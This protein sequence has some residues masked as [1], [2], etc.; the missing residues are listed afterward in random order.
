M[1]VNFAQR[2][3]QKKSFIPGL[4]A[5]LAFWCINFIAQNAFAQQAVKSELSSDT[6]FLKDRRA[7]KTI[8]VRAVK[9][10][11]AGA[12]VRNFSIYGIDDGLALRSVISGFKDHDGNL[13]FGTGGGGVSKFDGHTFTN[14]DER[15][16]IGNGV[17]RAIGQ[18]KSGNYYFG[19]RT[20]LSVY[21]GESI[22]NHYVRE[23]FPPRPI[24]CMTVDAS[25]NVW[26]GTHGGGLV[27][28]DGQKFTTYTTQNGLSSDIIRSLEIDKNGLLWIGTQDGVTTFDGDQ[29]KVFKTP[30]HSDNTVY[31]IHQDSKGNVWFACAEGVLK[32]DGRELNY[33][34]VKDGLSDSQILSIGESRDGILWFGTLEGG[35]TRFDGTS[36]EAITMKDGL[37]S[38]RI[39]GIINDA[40][41]SLWFCTHGGGVAR[42]NGNRLVGITTQQ[43]LAHNLVWSITQD[44]KGVLWFGHDI[45]FSSFDGDVFTSVTSEDSL[46]HFFAIEAD[47]K[48]NVWGGGRQGLIQ[49]N[50][51]N[52][53]QYTVAQG[54]LS[55]QVTDI[56][57][58]RSDV[59]WIGTEEGVTRFDGRSFTN[60]VLESGTGDRR[61]SRVFLDRNQTLWVS[62]T[63]K[64]FK[65][66]DSSSRFEQI[67]LPGFPENF[68]A[69][70]IVHDGHGNYWFGSRTGLVR[71]D[72][73]SCKHFNYENGMPNDRVFD[74]A[75]D[76]ITQDL[77][78]GTNLGL[79]K[80]SF[81]DKANL[82]VPAGALTIGNDVLRTFEPIWS[83]F[84]R[85]TGYPLDDLNHPALFISTQRESHAGA[86]PKS[87]LWAGFPD[88]LFRFDPATDEPASKITKPSIYNLKIDGQVVSWSTLKDKPSPDSL[89]EKQ[90]RLALGKSLTPEAREHLRRQLMGVR[91]KEVEKFSGLPTGLVLPH[92]VGQL[93]FDF[94]AIQ[95]SH[96]G[97][98]NYQYRL[99]G[100]QE[101]WS[102]PSKDLSA[103]FTNPWEGSYTFEVRAQSPDGTWTTPATFSFSVLPPW[104]RTW[105][106]YGAYLVV[107]ALLFFV[108]VK[109]RERKL[110]AEQQLLENIISE[111]T[112][113]VVEQMKSVELQKEE[114]EKQ[115]Q[116]ADR[117]RT[118][119]EEKNEEIAKQLADTEAS[120][121]NLTLQ[122]IQRFHAYSELEQELKKISETSDAKKYQ[123]A[124]SLIT[125]NK[126]LD[127]E[128]EQ[129]NFYFNG[130]YKDFNNKLREQSQQLSNYDL[131][132]CALIK[133]GLENREIAMLLNIEA[134]S[135]KMA[136]YRLKKKFNID[137]S[138]SLRSYSKH[139]R[140]YSF[141]VL[142]EMR[143][144]ALIA[145]V[146]FAQCADTMREN[147]QTPEV[148]VRLILD[149]D[150]AA[151][152][153]DA[154][155]VAVLHALADKR[156]VDILGMMVSMPVEYG[157][158]A[159]DAIN[160]FY[161]RPDIP[162]GTLKNSQE[163]AATGGLKTY[164]QDLTKRFPNDLKHGV[165][166]PNAVTLY[167]KLLA[168][169]NDAS[170][171]ILTI[172]PLTNLYH[173]LQSKGDSISS[174]TGV[175]LIKK[176]VK[177]LVTAGGRLPEGSSYNFWMAPEKTEY[178]VS[179]WPTEHWFAPNQLG[180]SVLTGDGLLKKTP[181]ENPVRMAYTLYRA[182]HPTWPFRPSWD[183]MA[184]LVAVR[185]SSGMFSTE[186]KG[187]VTVVG[188]KLR[189]T[190]DKDRDHVWFRT[191][192]S[193]ES[194]K[195]IIEDLMTQEPLKK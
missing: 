153:D 150:I 165:Y 48:G 120:L 98:I 28:Y 16:G 166:A 162:I 91:V 177:R 70:A 30:D 141:F 23:G 164:N 118:L 114:A 190:N 81:K 99:R 84:N 57:I 47:S 82:V 130:I 64:I 137:E 31:D 8:P 156:E 86:S 187:R 9:R 5:W 122:M 18:D 179:H 186:T 74:M 65:F 67:A 4:I 115:K 33:F 183:Q 10:V 25:D 184:V 173:L 132:M 161:N 180:D 108:F 93:T 195:D 52:L 142:F 19:T 22:T 76:P 131:R 94:G 72:G 174:L 168:D 138:V 113:E 100:Q 58:D 117:Q 128:W 40:E 78:M 172:G 121:S 192:T 167:R 35:V 2:L 182:T 79:L 189:W 95:T 147:E 119:V 1:L 34:S 105:P 149:T 171:T 135:V 27:K 123:R 146:A 14:L 55:N 83:Q 85:N 145:I 3:F 176:K 175:E 29:F 36:F 181:I 54:M 136:K 89:L 92:G 129:F 39:W 44:Q 73:K 7:P 151:D 15:H 140:R 170:V 68:T 51:K 43:G 90:E 50:G 71:Y 63:N 42:Y 24:V 13:W 143:I 111:R 80:L 97:R 88:K 112:N 144:S 124:F 159:L 32:F 133:M 41:G 75:I 155:A 194:L 59:L 38:N 126:S 26:C 103:T 188:D 61:V 66:D 178:V 6:I 134:S 11:R 152:C 169:E 160:T 96:G 53:V 12:P 106:M 21:N 87:V 154:G 20:G 127:K 45:G 185:P 101:Q 191:A 157:A 62:T 49:W 56:V 37:P 109:M 116:E 69:T 148:I 60:F 107:V 163:G 102:Y 104:W 125:M 110:L 139:C 158:P 193:S 77:W 17:V 46:F